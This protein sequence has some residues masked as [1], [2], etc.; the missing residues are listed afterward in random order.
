MAK[1]TYYEKLKDPRWQKKRLEAM[2]RKEFCCE[3][4]GDNET[5]LNVHHK[6]YFK[7]Y[8]PWE[9]ELDQ[10]AV[11]CESCHEIHHDNVDILKLV[12][13]Y[14]PIDGPGNREEL[15]FLIGG[16]LKFS[17]EGMLA[18]SGIDE[19]KSNKELHDL[20]S[21]VNFY[22]FSDLNKNRKSKNE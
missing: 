7:D 18:F 17:Y 11:L 22:Y 3:L 1:K 19:H 9:Y 10:L 8:E 4:C 21:Q 16:Y 15:A 13:S 6:E 2:Q 5:T 12:C 14:A 20:G